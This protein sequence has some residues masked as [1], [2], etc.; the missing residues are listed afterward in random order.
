M[1]I[2]LAV[3]PLSWWAADATTA[4]QNEHRVLREAPSAACSPRTAGAAPEPVALSRR[5][6][7]GELADGVN[8]TAPPG[9]F[10]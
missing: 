7:C 2:N 4:R 10:P 8:G 6:A 5:V 9:A 3:P 1:N